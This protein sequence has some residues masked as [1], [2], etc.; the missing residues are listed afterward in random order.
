MGNYTEYNETPKANPYANAAA[1]AKRADAFGRGLQNSIAQ[2][3]FFDDAET[4][5]NLTTTTTVAPPAG[6]EGAVLQSARSKHGG[7]VGQITD[8]SVVTINGVTATVKSAVNAG[9]ITKNADGSYSEVSKHT[10]SQPMKRD[11]VDPLSHD[12]R[13]GVQALENI[14]GKQNAENI[15]HRIVSA[16]GQGKGLGGV[17]KELADLAGIQPEV[18]EAIAERI[19]N[20]LD[21]KMMRTMVQGTGLTQPQAEVMLDW[22]YDNLP[23]QHVSAM[24]AGALHGD[25]GAIRVAFEKYRLSSRKVNNQ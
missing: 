3:I 24:F 19:E 11:R 10:P 8:D 2:F 20:D 1:P 22:C 16:C 4:T 9:L 23:K 21:A 5:E 13:A 12:S 6:Q 17:K 18:T 15:M 25:Q 14:V 7:P